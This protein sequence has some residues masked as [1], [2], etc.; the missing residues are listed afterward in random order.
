MSPLLWVGTIVGTA[1]G[2]CHGFYVYNCVRQQALKATPG[3]S[4]RSKA[5]IYA[6]WTLALWML[7]G[8]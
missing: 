1:C 5:T 7:F 4:D 6:I 8:V 3:S 2:L